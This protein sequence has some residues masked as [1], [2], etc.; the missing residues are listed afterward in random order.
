MNI[1]NLIACRTGSNSKA[2]P[3]NGSNCKD[4]LQILETADGGK[5]REIIISIGETGCIDAYSVLRKHIDSDYRHQALVAMGKIDYYGTLDIIVGLL[6]NSRE[7]T[8]K[9][10]DSVSCIMGD[11]VDGLGEDGFIKDLSYLSPLDIN[12]KWKIYRAIRDGIRFC[13]IKNPATYVNEI[14]SVLTI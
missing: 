1:E 6:R 7:N 5:K 9:T 14:R 3:Y 12:T 4:L 13:D 8:N 2:N 10:I 11:R